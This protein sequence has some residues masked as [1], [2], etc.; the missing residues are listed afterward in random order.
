MV[1]GFT[2]S[3]SHDG[4][5]A[6]AF[7]I[8][9]ALV[10][11][12]ALFVFVCVCKKLCSSCTGGV[13]IRCSTVGCS[14]TDGGAAGAVCDDCTDCAVLLA[15]CVLSASLRMPV[16]QSG[17]SAEALLPFCSGGPCGT[18]GI[19]GCCADVGGMP[20]PLVIVPIL[21]A[22]V[23]ASG[24]DGGAGAAGR[25]GCCIVCSGGN[26]RVVLA[27]GVVGRAGAGAF[28]AC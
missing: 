19:G 25:G 17:S 8:P 2:S 28:C 11:L 18:G 7:V 26:V 10:V 27:G 16:S 23:A 21:K 13:G 1:A 6:A 9:V 15:T 12:F 4:E 20:C 24:M 3:V 14:V 22:I 5:A